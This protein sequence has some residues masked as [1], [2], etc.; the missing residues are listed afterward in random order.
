MEL[1]FSIVRIDVSQQPNTA[2]HVVQVAARPVM[3]AG[4]FAPGLL[5]T[6]EV[7]IPAAA[8]NEIA[9][10]ALQ[11]ARSLLNESAAVAYFQALPA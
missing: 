9:A 3:T 11:S 6:V 2:P 4:G 5:L 10:A 8:L 7:A 1:S